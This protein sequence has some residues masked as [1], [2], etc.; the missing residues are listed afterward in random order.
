MIMFRFSAVSSGIAALVAFVLA[1]ALINHG[2]VDS[3]L[4]VGPGLTL[5]E[6]FN[7]DQGVY[8]VDALGQHGPLVFQPSVAEKVFGD[9]RYLPDHP[10]LGRI[11]LGMAHELTAW[12]IPGSEQ[13]I[14]NVPAA[15]LGSCFAFAVTVL[16]LCEFAR[17]K[18]GTVTSICVALM[19]IGMPHLIGHARLAAL[20]ST[21]NLAWVLAMLPMLGWWTSDKPPSNLH[22]V[23]SGACW[24]ILMLTKV[25]AVF[26][27]PIVFL[28]AV[29]R[30]QWRAIRPLII[31]GV[32]GGLI[33]LG[34]WPW[35]WSNP[36]DNVMAFLGR[37][38]ERQTLYCWYL[39]E[40]FADKTVPW[41]FPFVMTLISLPAWSVA[42]LM[43][44]A[45]RV[46]RSKVQLDAAEQFL[47]LCI[48]FPLIVFA[49][50]GVPVYDGTR[51]F[52]IVMPA[53]AVL[54]A[55][56][57]AMML[58]GMKSCWRRNLALTILCCVP[59]YWIMQPLAISQYG[60]LAGGNRGAAWLGMEAS[61][62]SDALNSD[63]WNQVP[64]DSTIFVAPVSHQ[65]QLPDLATLVPVVQ[66]RRIQLVAYEYER[67]RQKGKLLLLHRLADLR[68]SLQTV[69]E[70]SRLLIEV[71]LDGVP[72]VRLID[73]TDTTLPE[74][75]Q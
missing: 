19:L 34:G 42:G 57:M 24:G 36:Y 28:W 9:V 46:I 52:L 64:E 2:L 39:G 3:R 40:R 67:N 31:Y 58:A 61:Y 49:L 35:L 44:R 8:L 22:A 75:V 17:R 11:I 38:T 51:L 45:L 53:L 54:S 63:F 62:W 6:S 73:T 27:P 65:F 60:L 12:L 5:D 74:L 33:F 71:T 55:R 69:P 20:E 14:Y 1:A 56:G 48:V 15:R 29:W 68:R 7:I 50:P 47:L 10:P 59:L 72:L 37:T 41:H 32:A 30:F 18:Y 25:Q 4:P 21:T 16:L 70:G 13:T 26:F 66:H 43:L 23:F